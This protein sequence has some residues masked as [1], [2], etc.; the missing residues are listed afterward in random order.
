MAIRLFFPIRFF[1][2]ITVGDVSKLEV[3]MMRPVALRMVTRQG[4]SK[5]GLMNAVSSSYT[6]N[7][8][9]HTHFV[10][11]PCNSCSP[12]TAAMRY[13]SDRFALVSPVK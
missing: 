7:T 8:G 1:F 3:A 2:P 5:P 11:R 12:D 6:G 9:E 13:C 4:I 10:P